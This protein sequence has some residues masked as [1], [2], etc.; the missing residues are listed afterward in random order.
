MAATDARP[1][2]IKN[3]AYRLYLD[4]RKNDGTLVT[5]WAGADTELSADGAAFADA[6]NEITEIGTSGVGYIDLTSGEMNYDCVTVKS[7]VTNTDALPSVIYLYPEEA[8]DINVDVTAFGGTA[9]TFASGRPEV[10]T[11]H[12]AGTAWASGA[13]TAASIATGAIDADALAADAVN[14]IADGIFVRNMSNMEGT[15]GEHTLCTLVLAA[16][17]GSRSGTTWLIKRTDGSTTH[18]TKTLTTDAA[19]ELVTGIT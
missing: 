18:A 11:T 8:G 14:E 1:V 16:L 7:T 17:E 10:N 2:P 19:A 15:A 9:G 13:I 5:T 6:T 12:A 4:M 3:T